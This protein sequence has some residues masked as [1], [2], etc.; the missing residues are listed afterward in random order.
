MFARFLEVSNLLMS[1]P[2]CSPTRYSEAKK[3]AADYQ[4]A[5]TEVNEALYRA[6]CGHWIEKPVEQD[7]FS[8]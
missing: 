8:M 2:I 4:R 5:K 6:G 7:Q 1:T 3:L